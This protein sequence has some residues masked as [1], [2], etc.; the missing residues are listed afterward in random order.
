[1]R[2]DGVNLSSADAHIRHQHAY[3]DAD[4]GAHY[5]L[6]LKMEN[7]R[8]WNRRLLSFMKLENDSFVAPLFLKQARPR[9]DR[10]QELLTHYTPRLLDIA[11]AL[12]AE[13]IQLF[14]Y[15]EDVALLEEILILRDD[16]LRDGPRH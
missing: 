3:C 4:R 5:D 7:R 6:L 16:I 12:Y 9:A 11:K 8:C 14:G 13:D 1:M 2:N 15:G 10:L